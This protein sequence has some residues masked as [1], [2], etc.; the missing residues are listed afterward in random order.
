MQMGTP[1]SKF[2]NTV[3]WLTDF[4]K[5]KRSTAQAAAYQD[6]GGTWFDSNCGWMGTAQIQA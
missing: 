2:R 4:D 5:G 3:P 6:N 1:F